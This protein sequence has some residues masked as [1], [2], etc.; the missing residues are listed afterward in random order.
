MNLNINLEDIVRI[1]IS[2]FTLAVPTSFSNNHGG[3]SEPTF[4]V[5]RLFIIIIHASIGPIVADSF[6]KE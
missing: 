5:K 6:S 3:W 1:I 4:A 2:P